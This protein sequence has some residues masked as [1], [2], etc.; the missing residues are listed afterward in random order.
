MIYL[1]LKIHKKT[2]LK[3]LGKTIQDPFKYR[4]SGVR[5]VSHLKV[6]GNDVSTVIL[7]EC[8]NEEDLKQWGLY[9]SNLW[10]VVESA[11]FANLVVEAGDNS[12]KKTHSILELYNDPIWQ[13]TVG[14]CKRN[15]MRGN[16]N[17]HGTIPITNGTTN[18]RIKC[19]APMPDGWYKG[20][21]LSEATRKKMSLAKLKRNLNSENS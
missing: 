16:R 5:W 20:N 21:T 1:Y 4:G 17:G 3:Y 12:E 7:K 19:S 9:F 10:N 11:E 15:K 8:S 13:A 14:E 18:S 6:H 2:G